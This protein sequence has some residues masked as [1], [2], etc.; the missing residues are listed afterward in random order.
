MENVEKIVM[1]PGSV[2][3][4]KIYPHPH[5]ASNQTFWEYDRTAPMTL[6]DAFRTYRYDVILNSRQRM[7]Q[8]KAKETRRQLAKEMLIRGGG[9]ADNDAAETELYK[10]IEERLKYESKRQVIDRHRQFA[11]K[12]RRFAHFEELAYPGMRVR[13]VPH[14]VPSYQPSSGGMSSREIKER[15]RRKYQ[16]LPEVQQKLLREKLEENKAKNRIKSNIFK[17]VNFY[18]N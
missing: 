7:R 9:A 11:Q 13:S 18:P 12:N 14:V 5:Q 8:L 2:H 3:E 1:P 17:K 4:P 10:S 16:R 6:Q 15:T